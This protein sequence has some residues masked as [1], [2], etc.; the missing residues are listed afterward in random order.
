M[1][2]RYD[3]ISG[4]V[5]FPLYMNL[6]VRTGI[7]TGISARE[8]LYRDL[9]IAHCSLLT[10]TLLQSTLENNI[11]QPE[12]R[13]MFRFCHLTVI[14]FWCSLLRKQ[15]RN[16][17]SRSPGQSGRCLCYVFNACNAYISRVLVQPICHINFA[18][19]LPKDISSPTRYIA[20]TF[21][22]VVILSILLSQINLANIFV[23]SKPTILI[24]TL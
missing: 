5:Q 23:T 15:W 3:R 7:R 14:V 22:L 18:L 4:I 19:Q 9:H 8:N 6:V 12:K 11:L 20:E 17:S 21:F 24:R 16:R 10:E 1:G 13:S 2:V